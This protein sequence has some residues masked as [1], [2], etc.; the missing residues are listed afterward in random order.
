MSGQ[1]VS[2]LGEKLAELTGKSTL[3]CSG[4][5]RFAIRDIQKKPEDLNLQ[6]WMNVL[7]KPLI[8]RLEKIRALNPEQIAGQIRDFLTNNQSVLTMAV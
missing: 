8:M 1:I 6:G 5:I 2:M 4:I 7:Q 3:A